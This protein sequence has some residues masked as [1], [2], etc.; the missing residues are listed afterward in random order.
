MSILNAGMAGLSISS[1]EQRLEEGTASSA[2]SSSGSSPREMPQGTR[3]ETEHAP[4]QPISIPSR[5][6]RFH[7]AVIPAWRSERHERRAPTLGDAPE[8]STSAQEGPRNSAH[9]VEKQHGT[10]RDAKRPSVREH[11]VWRVNHRTTPL[12][13]QETRPVAAPTPPKATPPRVKDRAVRSPEAREPAH[14]GQERPYTTAYTTPAA[15]LSEG[16]TSS[17]SP[18][19]KKQAAEASQS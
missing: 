9:T 13:R 15:K 8:S 6:P 16:A 1:R 18:R 11:H 14:S 10:G 17:E 19:L 3:G 7:P 12:S 2:S 4:T 5:R